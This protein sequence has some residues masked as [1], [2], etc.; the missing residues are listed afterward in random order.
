MVIGWVVVDSFMCVVVWLSKLIVLF[1]R[2]CVVMQWLDNLVVVM[3]VFLEMLILWCVLKVLCRLCRIMMVWVIVGLGI[4]IGWKCCFSVVFF[5]MY[6]WYLFSVVVL[7]RLS[8]LCVIIGLN[9]LV[10]FSLFLLL[11]WL[12]LMMVCILLMN[13]ISLFWCLVIF[14]SIFCM[15]FLNLL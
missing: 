13:K 4:V 10:M 15:C 5:L 1:G 3:I 8:L 9:M 2:K 14:F 11:F 6:F 12:V 7:I